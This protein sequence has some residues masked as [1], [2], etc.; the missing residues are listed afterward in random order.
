MRIEAGRTTAMTMRLWY[1]SMTPFEHLAN[2]RAALEERAAK[3]CSPGVDVSF[4]GMPPELYRNRTPADVLK[5]PYGKLMGQLEVIEI[6]R[7]RESE[8]FDAVILGSFSE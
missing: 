8:G 2:Y 3:V 6:C 4:G 1:Q 7:R 5:Y